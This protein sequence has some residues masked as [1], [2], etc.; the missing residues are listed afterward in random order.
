MIC[1]LYLLYVAARRQ[2]AL[3]QHR[4]CMMRTRQLH[5]Q[6]VILGKEMLAALIAERQSE[7]RL[8]QAGS[9]IAEVFRG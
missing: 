2:H 9:P 8:Q 3:Y 6:Y 5:Q 4:H 1:W 7:L